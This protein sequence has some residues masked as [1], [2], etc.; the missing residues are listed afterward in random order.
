MMIDNSCFFLCSY[1]MVYM[2]NQGT[3]L[4]WSFV[5]GL[6]STKFKEDINKVL[7]SIKLD[8]LYNFYVNYDA[9]ELGFT[10][11]CG[12]HMPREWMLT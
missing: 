6:V 8:N 9:G 12:I 11:L 10:V 3:E 1:F 5:Q 7:D 2:E 4:L